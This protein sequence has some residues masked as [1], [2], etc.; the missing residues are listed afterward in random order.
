MYPGILAALAERLHAA[1]ELAVSH[2]PS[3]WNFHCKPISMSATSSS[4]G[5]IPEGAAT[6]GASVVRVALYIFQHAH[7]IPIVGVGKEMSTLIGPYMYV[8]MY[9]Y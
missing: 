3:R 7:F 1:P 8:C 6:P 4:G 9:I 2:V 5:S